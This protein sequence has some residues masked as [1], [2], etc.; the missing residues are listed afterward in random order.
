MT[1]NGSESVV[2]NEDWGFVTGMCPAM[3][4]LESVIAEIA[5]TNI[6]VLF[7]GE[8]GTG[9]AMFAQRIH[10]LSTR[11]EEALITVSCA[12]MNPAQLSAELRL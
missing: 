5:P 1:T 8:S 9:K 7:L 12:A 6:P 10:Q 4:T 3:Q 11:S 2:I